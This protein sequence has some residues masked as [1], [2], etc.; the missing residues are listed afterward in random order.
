MARKITLGALEAILER[1]GVYHSGR[2]EVRL[3]DAGFYKVEKDG[4]T[5]LYSDLRDAWRAI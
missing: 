3:T 2:A 4:V 1:E 5:R